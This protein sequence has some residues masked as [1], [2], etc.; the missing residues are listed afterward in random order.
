MKKDD[1]FYKK[2]C[3]GEK[4]LLRMLTNSKNFDPIMG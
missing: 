1:E 3:C 4:S 2:V